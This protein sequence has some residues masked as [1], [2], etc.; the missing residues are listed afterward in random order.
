MPVSGRKGVIVTCKP[1]A[2]GLGGGAGGGSEGGGPCCAAAGLAVHRS[3][4]A[5]RRDSSIRHGS[6]ARPAID[7]F[8][9]QSVAVPKTARDEGTKGEPVSDQY[10]TRSWRL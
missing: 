5:P 9:T 2:S 1:D 4:Q 10:S 8:C 7:P 6:T 3:R